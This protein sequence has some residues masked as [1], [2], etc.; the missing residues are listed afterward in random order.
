MRRGA[1]S[2]G[3]HRD[4][5]DLQL[6]EMPARTHASHG[7]SW[8]LALSLRLAAFETL[9]EIG[10]EPPILIL[11]DV[12]AELDETRRG[13]LLA[14]ISL[15]EQVFVTAAVTADVP[16]GIVGQRWQVDAGDTSHVE[17]ETA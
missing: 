6:N 15:A 16:T 1:T 12:F 8:S 7:E 17:L 11:D 2:V 9:T 4:D 3:P 10:G 14:A 5:L 13:R